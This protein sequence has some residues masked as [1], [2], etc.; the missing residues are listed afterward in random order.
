ME[1]KTNPSRRKVR[2]STILIILF[3][4]GTFLSVVFGPVSPRQSDTDIGSDTF[5]E[6][7]EIQKIESDARNY[8]ECVDNVMQGY[9]RVTAE[10][11]LRRCKNI[12]GIN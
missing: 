1:N 7:A 6:N 9:V 8:Q 2:P 10:Y 12:Y 5:K 3:L 4:I 11:D